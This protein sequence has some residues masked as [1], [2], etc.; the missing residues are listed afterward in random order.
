[1]P[2]PLRRGD[3]GDAGGDGTRG[4]AGGQGQDRPQ[5]GQGRREAGEGGGGPRRHLGRRRDRQDG[6]R[7]HGRREGR[8]RGRH[9]GRRPAGDGQDPDDDRRRGRR[10]GGGRRGLRRGRHLGDGEVLRQ[11]GP[12]GHRGLHV[13]RPP[14]GAD[15]DPEAGRRGGDVADHAGQGGGRAGR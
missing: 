13:R 6:D 7:R 9:R 3:G 1:Q 14:A 8:R 12:G 10:R 11:H 5:A 15:R 2:H 4:G